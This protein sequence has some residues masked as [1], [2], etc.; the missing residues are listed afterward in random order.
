MEDRRTVRVAA[1][2]IHRDGR[3][4]AAHRTDAALPGGWELPGGKI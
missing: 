1:G 4:L 3:I 2:I